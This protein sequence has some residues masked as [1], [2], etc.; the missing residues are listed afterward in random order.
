MVKNIK[1]SPLRDKIDVK[2]LEGVLEDFREVTCF[3]GHAVDKNNL[4]I[5]EPHW[6]LDICKLM[7][8]SDAGIS[9]CN[10]FAL[11]VISESKTTGKLMIYPCHAG[12]MNMA[13]PL[14]ITGKWIALIFC[15]CFRVRSFET[16]G[17]M[18]LAEELD[19]NPAVLEA[20]VKNLKKHLHP[21]AETETP[22]AALLK[23]LFER[24][25]LTY[26]SKELSQTFGLEERLAL[27][28]ERVR[29]L[30]GTESSAAVLITGKNIEVRAK[31]INYNK[32]DSSNPFVQNI[33]ASFNTQAESEA[34]LNILQFE[35][36][37]SYEY[38]FLHRNKR[39]VGI[40]YAF[41]SFDHQLNEN[42]RHLLNAFASQASLSIANSLLYQDKIRQ[43]EEFDRIVEAI[44]SGED[45]MN[46]LKQILYIGLNLVQ[47]PVGWIAL[48]DENKEYL[49]V[50]VEKGFTKKTKLKL[51]LEKGLQAGLQRRESR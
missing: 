38:A 43:F 45:P 50:V 14:R 6:E 5:T 48:V 9:K 47:I 29:D 19:L 30:I 26:I 23:S 32:S 22:Y 44:T 10:K 8:S 21:L 17:C 7:R 34:L 39:T 27:I 1:Y 2:F 46:V 28:A 49:N 36:V 4:F 24:T 13:I 51:K 16:D 25:A 15:H 41:N 20:A 3:K 37:E 18:K 42:Q 35:G 12:L 31:G 11:K 40:I 33:T